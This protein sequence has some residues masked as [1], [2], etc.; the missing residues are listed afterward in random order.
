MYEWFERTDR[1]KVDS[2]NKHYRLEIHR[3]TFE[4]SHQ[5]LP[6]MT[7]SFIFFE[8]EIRFL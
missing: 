5:R 7:K 6:R 1:E 4:E 8:N 2:P 3:K